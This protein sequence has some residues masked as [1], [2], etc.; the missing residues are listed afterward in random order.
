MFTASVFSRMWS[1]PPKD[2]TGSVY[3]S[4]TRVC[5]CLHTPICRFAL[6][7]RHTHAHKHTQLCGFINTLSINSLTLSCCDFPTLITPSF[8]PF[9]SLFPPLPLPLPLPPS[10]SLPLSLTYSF[11]HGSP[12]WSTSSVIHH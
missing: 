2:Y 9:L 4:H 10:L 8:I 7:H 3:L 11:F 5:E 12:L 1:L 6:T